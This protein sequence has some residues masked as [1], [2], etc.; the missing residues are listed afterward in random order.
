MGGVCVNVGYLQKKLPKK[1]KKFTLY[2]QFFV[3]T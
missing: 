3:Y 1:Y 2:Y